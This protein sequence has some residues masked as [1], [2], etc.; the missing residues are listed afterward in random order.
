MTGDDDPLDVMAEHLPVGM[1][2]ASE[3]TACP[4]GKHDDYV[5]SMTLFFKI[6]EYPLARYGRFTYY[7]NSLRNR[8]TPQIDESDLWLIH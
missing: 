6:L 2:F 3:L 4:L 8:L 7:N 5:D 1:E